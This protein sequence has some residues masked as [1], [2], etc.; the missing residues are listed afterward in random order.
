[1]SCVDRI[2][3]ILKKKCRKGNAESC[4]IDVGL[5]VFCKHIPKIRLASLHCLRMFLQKKKDSFNFMLA[6]IFPVQCK[7]SVLRLTRKRYA[8]LQIRWFIHKCL[9]I[10]VEQR[11]LRRDSTLAGIWKRCFIF[12]LGTKKLLPLSCAGSLTLTYALSVTIF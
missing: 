7:G 6:V 3:R 2:R 12:L 10:E 1:M 11:Q 4:I 5:I 8:F 9:T